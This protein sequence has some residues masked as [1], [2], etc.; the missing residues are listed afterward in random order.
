MS[1]GY[2]TYRKDDE[3]YALDPKPGTPRTLRKF[4]GL[5]DATPKFDSAQTIDDRTRR[6]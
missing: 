1:V 2:R 5:L 4:V 6:T 3:Y